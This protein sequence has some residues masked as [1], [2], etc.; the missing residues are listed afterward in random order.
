MRVVLPVYYAAAGESI[1]KI[2]FLFFLFKL[3]EVVAPMGMGL[4]LNRFGYK[5]TFVSAIGIHTLISCFYLLPVSALV[6]LE[7]FVRGVVYMSDMSAV[8]VKHFSVRETQRFL[9]NMILGLKE[10][11]K[12]VGMAVGGLLL[13]VFAL[14]NTVLVFAAV[15][16]ASTLMAMLFLP[17]LKEQSRTPVH[18]IWRTVDSKIKTLGLSFG[19]LHGALDAWGVVLLPV[20][21]TTEFGLSPAVVGALMMGKYVFHGV[22]VTAFSR[23]TNIPADGR[24]VLLTSALALIAVTLSLSVPLSLYPF[25]ALVFFYLFL[26]SV[27]MVYYNHL[28]LEF[29]SET[30]TSLDLAAFTTLSNVVKPIAVLASGLLAESL[31]SS[32]AYYFAALLTL[33]SGLSCLWL[34]RSAARPSAL[35]RVYE[36]GS[37]LIKGPGR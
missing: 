28:R 16:A 9:V 10:A 5:R 15:T 11:S 20:Y 31:G 35:L 30:Q 2:A 1:S 14:R 17:D 34:P 24:T 25:L 23:Y 13:S 33:F 21:L 18:K 32:W 27:S 12:G 7:R 6:F 37:T 22:V 36:T 19:L 4:T 29:A 26:F 8:Y 3:A